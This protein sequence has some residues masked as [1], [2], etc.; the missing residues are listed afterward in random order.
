MCRDQKMLQAWL[1]GRNLG[2]TVV[3]DGGQRVQKMWSWPVEADYEEF[4]YKSHGGY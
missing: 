2:Y 4:G 1:G 3:E